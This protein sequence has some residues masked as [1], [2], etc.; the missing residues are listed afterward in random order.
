MSDQAPEFRYCETCDVQQ[1]VM[2]EETTDGG[3]P[4]P[5]WFHVIYLDCG[6][7][8]VTQVKAQVRW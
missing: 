1:E 4:D 5:R 3:D 8:I 2:D 7:N 6:H